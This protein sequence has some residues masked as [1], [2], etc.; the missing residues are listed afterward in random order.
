[1]REWNRVAAAGRRVLAGMAAAAVQA[2]RAGI[3]SAVA[4][5]RVPG[6]TAFAAGLMVVAF[7]CVLCGGCSAE[8]AAPVTITVIHAWG[9]TEDD[10]VA[11][12]RIYEDFQEENPDVQLQM[13][14]M[15][16]REEMLRKVEDRIMV[17]N[18]PD[19]VAFGGMGRNETYDFMVQNGMALDLMPYLEEDKAFA[20]S[21]SAV[22]LEH[23]TTQD[24]QLF[25]VSDVLVLSGGY[26]YNEEMFERA[27][28]RELPQTWGE[29]TAMCG[30]LQRWSER[31]NAGVKPLQASPEGYL[32]FFDHMIGGRKEEVS[33][34]EN[35]RW[36][37]GAGSGAE[38]AQALWWLGEIYRFSTSGNEGYSYRDE[39]SLFNEGKLAIYVNGVWGAP[40]IAEEI[41]A[42][43]ALLPTGSGI[44]RSCQ[45]ACL[46]YVLG[47]SG[48][49]EREEASVRFL[50]YML[51]ED[52]Q[53]RIL[54][55]TGQIPANPNVSLAE[56]AGENPRLYQAASLVLGADEKIEVPDNL[57]TAAEK[58]AFTGNI[59]KILEQNQAQGTEQEE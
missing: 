38:T 39:T 14:P 20:R 7:L 53:R 10:H 27:G 21:V 8:S 30:A 22:N 17:G 16:T 12:R 36:N 57:W 34:E 31:E 3:A 1:M 45:S 33:V 47:N 43:Y 44:S 48:N 19:V 9:S 55:E 18:T 13:I 28:I 6:R 59:V 29:F 25:T 56:S 37:F 11:M 41:R 52:V 2:G 49:S 58:E 50:K 40:M 23:W 4:G 32:Y 24:N 5:R 35:G 42:S 15:P 54:K 26:W 46:G 51:R